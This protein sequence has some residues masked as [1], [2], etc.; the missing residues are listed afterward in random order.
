M[1]APHANSSDMEAGRQRSA[2]GAIA[3]RPVN[4]TAQHVDDDEL[5]RTEA[6][7]GEADAEEELVV[8]ASYGEIAKHF[9][10]LG[11]TA[12]G[13]PAA[14]VNMFLKVK[15]KHSIQLLETFA[16]LR[17]ASPRL[18]GYCFLSARPSYLL[19]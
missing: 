13:G 6:L 18:H 12:F 7:L 5:Q 15:Q 3:G 1:T 16:K 17:F 19:D 11:W 14:H 10:Y 8:P 2:A 9:A 4:N